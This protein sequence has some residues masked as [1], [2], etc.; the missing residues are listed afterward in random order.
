[1]RYPLDTPCEADGIAGSSSYRSPGMGGAWKALNFGS[2]ITCPPAKEFHGT[3]NC[4][5][6]GLMFDSTIHGFFASYLLANPNV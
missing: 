3:I 5:Q 4:V 6:N 1:M 2:L